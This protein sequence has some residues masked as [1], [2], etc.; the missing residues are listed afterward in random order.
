MKQLLLLVVFISSFNHAQTGYM[1]TSFNVSLGDL[2]TKHCEMDSLANALLIY[3]YGKSHVNQSDY[4]LVFEYQNKTKILTR[5]GF[6]EGNISIYLYNSDNKKEKLKNLKAVTYNIENNRIEK[7]EVSKKDIFEEKYN[8]N[9][10]I[11]KFTFPNLKVGSV[12]AYSYEIRSPFMYKFQPWTFQSDIPTLYS[13]YNT[14]VPANFEYNIKLVGGMK[15]ST[16]TAELERHCLQGSYGASADCTVSQYIMQNIPAFRK[17]S[18]MTTRDNYLAR[19]EYELKTFKGFD[20]TVKN[21]TKTWDTADKEIRTD[22]NIG[23]QLGKSNVVRDLL[24]DT[25]TNEANPLEKAKK[26]LEYVQN[27]YVWDETYSLFKDVSIKN[28]IK[29]KSGSAT[30][31]NILLHN[32]LVENDI[33]TKPV[34]IST[35]ENGLPTK[36]FPVISEFNYL[37]VQVNINNQQYF[38]D[39]TDKYLSFGEIP[40]RCLNQYGRLM[41]FE[42]SSQW[43]DITPSN[44]SYVQIRADLTFDENQDSFTGP[45]TTKRTGYHALNSKKKYFGNPTL[46][47]ENLAN[48][49]DQL[50]ISDHSITSEG[51]ND[52]NFEETYNV[53]SEVDTSGEKLYLNPFLIKFFEENPFKLEERTYPIDFGYKDTFMYSCSFD[54]NGQYDI[55]ELPKEFNI[56]LPDKAGT[57]IFYTRVLEDKIVVFFKLSF[58][59]EI[60]P[61]NYYVSLKKFM[62][63]IVNCQNNSLIVLKKK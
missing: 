55:L 8:D 33:D 13:E 57:A 9:Y 45:I 43:I 50:T 61:A 58:N 24:D 51:P 42:N 14:K 36:I 44:V 62:G 20:G 11:V 10:T 48:D 49:F 54:L 59:L 41:D 21:Y 19:I 39:A 46:Y 16:N 4:D 31:I 22:P 40:F 6:D 28:L 37:L 25:I 7:M 38:L 23:R 52:L 35:R 15:L 26:I 2:N 30:E 47:V 32:L 18:Y 3:E 5:E 27:N 63:M 29:E 17:E 12:I 53:T 60:Y 1:T 34:L 56:G